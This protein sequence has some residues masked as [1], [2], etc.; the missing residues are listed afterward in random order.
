MTVTIAAKV[1]ARYRNCYVPARTLPQRGSPPNLLTEAAATS[2][3]LKSVTENPEAIVKH[4]LDMARALCEAGSAGLSML[5]RTETSDEEPLRW[6]AL[7][8]VL[9]SHPAIDTR[10]DHSPCGLCLD[11]G[12]AILVSRPQQVFEGWASK[13]PAITEVLTVPL[14]DAMCAPLGTMWIAHHDSDCRFSSNDV[15]IAEQVAAKLTLTLVLR[16]Q[17][18]R[19]D[20]AME[21]SRSHHRAHLKK[22]AQVLKKERSSH[23]QT[24]ITN[25]QALKLKD[26]LIQ[27]TN[28]RA[29]N[30]LQIAA[31][32]LIMQSRSSSSEVARQVLIDNAHRIH[33]LGKTHELL[34][35]SS[36]ST[37]IIF[38]P[39]LLNALA[40]SLRQSFHHTHPAVKLMV[41]CDPVELPTQIATPLALITNEAITNA[42][43]HAFMNGDPGVITV[44]LLRQN[45]ADLCLRIEDTGSGHDTF[46]QDEGM[47]M[48]LIRALGAQLGGKLDVASAD[49]HSGTSVELNVSR[50]P[51]ID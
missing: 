17:A 34:Y 25:R 7:S 44:K 29:K 46:N 22:L 50:S 48:A 5:D 26:T 15:R 41:V 13:L 43:K 30:T 23:E 16:E 33:I 49:R 39:L 32:L 47:G 31:N 4:L 45:E 38:M 2:A 21:A 12:I 27:D 3:L 1:E 35:S 42:Y 36:G 6:E 10:R 37:Q 18:H 9:S 20:I 28:H 8:G 11:A 24:R 19:N 14:F 51:R 40:D